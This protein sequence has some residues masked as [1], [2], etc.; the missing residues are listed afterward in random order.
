MNYHDN[1]EKEITASVAQPPESTSMHLP[2]SKKS[3]RVELVL[4]RAWDTRKCSL[5]VH[6]AS[7]WWSEKALSFVDQ[8]ATKGSEKAVP[9]TRGVPR[10]SPIQVLTAPDVAQRARS[11]GFACVQ[12][13]MVVGE[14]RL[15]RTLI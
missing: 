2:V 4:F 13:G 5:R 6:G 14:E 12:R 3:L 11:D 1:S 10:P 15:R 7:L 9:T 8:R